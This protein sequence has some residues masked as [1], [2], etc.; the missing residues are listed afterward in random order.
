MSFRPSV[1]QHGTTLFPLNGFSCIWYWRNVRKSD[2][3]IQVS[4]K[5]DKNK[6]YFIWRPIY[7][8]LSYIAHFFLEWEMFQ[9]NFVEKIKTHMC[10][11]IPQPPEIVPCIM[12]KNTV[13]TDRPQMTIWRVCI[14][15]WIPKAT[16][17]HTQFWNNHCFSIVTMVAQTCLNVTSY[18]HWLSC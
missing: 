6:G 15:C 13:E 17:T 7:I 4:L 16:N 9:S 10:S 5:S 2:E 1:R 3:Q 18:V 14:A 12:W 11:E 8:F